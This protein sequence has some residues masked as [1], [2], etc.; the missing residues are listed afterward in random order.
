MAQAEVVIMPEDR[1]GKKCLFESKIG[2]NE[3][4]SAIRNNVK[5]VMM[6]NSSF[7]DY[8]SQ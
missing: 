1:V 2:K 4:Y 3:S 8:H 5:E 7:L 6:L